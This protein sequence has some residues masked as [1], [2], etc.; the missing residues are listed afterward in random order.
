MAGS[1]TDGSRPRRR[2]RSPVGGGARLSALVVAATMVAG[3]SGDRATAQKGLIIGA[4]S[5]TSTAAPEPTIPPEESTTSSTEPAPTTTAA[6][7]VV[8][9][10][11]PGFPDGAPYGPAVPF[12]SAVAVP[13]DLVFVLVVGS[14][15]RPGQ[16][17]RRTNGDSIH[18]LAVDPR[19]GAGTV[20]GIPRDSW[21]EV[22]GRGTR[23]IN[24]A[25]ALGGPQLMAETVRHLT[26][27]PV[28]YYVVTGFEGFERI[29]DDLGG[30]HVHVDRKMDDY[31]SGARFDPGWHHMDGAEALA[32]SRNRKDTQNGDF[33]RS[34]HQGN[35]ILSAL[36]KLRA[37]VGDDEGIARWVGVLLKHAD[38]DSPP[39]QLTQLATLARHLD[40]A[41]LTNLVVPGRVGTAGRASVVFLGDE[42]RQIFLDL[43]PDA[44][45]GGPKGDE[46]RPAAQAKPA[47]EP[48]PAPAPDPAPTTTTAPPATTTTTTRPVIDLTS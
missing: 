34:L 10:P 20:V 37:E 26:G 45:I 13:Q 17:M 41:K 5:T 21:V 32:Y 35:V 9:P 15:A 6:P 40:P 39:Q 3:C 42:A 14:D 46:P 48:E 7:V 29:V 24:A 16:D 38:L 2:G 25:L 28:H 4:S 22:P 1:Q 27:L 19:T 8:P 31:F 30:V 43:R 47:P 18:L 11:P 44:A 33:S 36:A 23:K 12:R